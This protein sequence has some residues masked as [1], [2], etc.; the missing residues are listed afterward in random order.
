MK[1]NIKTTQPA[2]FQPY[3]AKLE[4]ATPP[5]GRIWGK[6]S[7][8]VLLKRYSQDRLKIAKLKGILR[9]TTLTDLVARVIFPIQILLISAGRYTIATF[10]S[11]WLKIYRLPNPLLIIFALTES[12]SRD[13]LLQKVYSYTTDNFFL[14]SCR[15]LCFLRFKYKVPVHFTTF[16]LLNVLVPFTIFTTPTIHLVYFPPPKKLQDHCFQSSQ[17]KK[18]NNADAIFQ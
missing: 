11:I 6:G 13:Q 15:N 10:W 12:L 5:K 8:C 9:K 7:R 17:E 4:G 16:F 1:E 18:L 2:D 14:V 3:I